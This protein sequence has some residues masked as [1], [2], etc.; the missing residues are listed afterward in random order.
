MHAV[1]IYYNSAIMAKK[2]SKDKDASPQRSSKIARVSEKNKDVGK[3]KETE[4][5]VAP[6]LAGNAARGSSTRGDK[7]AEVGSH[8]SPFL[9]HPFPSFPVMDMPQSAV[10]YVSP[11]ATTRKVDKEA[12]FRSAGNVFPA[13]RKFA[14]LTDN[15]GVSSPERD[16]LDFARKLAGHHPQRHSSAFSSRGSSYAPPSGH[17][18]S[19]ESDTARQIFELQNSVMLLRTE[20]ASNAASAQR[21]LPS[22]SNVV[23]TAS[24]VGG[25]AAGNA[26]VNLSSIATSVQHGLPSVSNIAHTASIM[27][28]VA[29]GNASVNLASKATSIQRGLPSVPNIVNAA[30]TVGGEAAGTASTGLTHTVHAVGGVVTNSTNRN[31]PATSARPSVPRIGRSV[32]AGGS[33]GVGVNVAVKFTRS[34]SGCSRHLCFAV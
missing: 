28:G 15:Q 34:D 30:S 10:K 2:R 31:L 33:I 25:E 18:K 23:H 7:S 21:S 29:A 8:A 11:P 12:V 27:G 32:S 17:V 26:S 16:V 1:V 13:H 6:V 4:E 3:A 20:F 9:M 22:V 24:T 14:V 5:I 19:A